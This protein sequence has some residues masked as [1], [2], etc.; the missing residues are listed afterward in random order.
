MNPKV[1]FVLHAHL[2][3]VRHIEYPKFLEENWLFESINETYIPLL[4]T[5]QNL[6]EVDFKISICFSPTLCAMLTD[7]M[8]Q[9]RFINY[10]EERITLGIK[11]VLRCKNEKLESLDM[12][13]KYLNSNRENLSYYKKCKRDLLYGFRQLQDLGKV[14]LLATAA[15]NIYFPVYKEYESVISAEIKIGIDEHI[16]YFGNKPDGFLLP[17]NGYYPGIEDFFEEFSIKWISLASSA[18][19]LAKNK[20]ESAGLCPVAI[21]ESSVLGF[22]R[23]WAITN[24]IWSDKTG[25]PCD[26]DY[27]DFYSDIG[28][29]L[30]LDYI[31]PFIHEPNVRVFTSYK[32][33]TIGIDGNKNIYN[34][35]KAMAKVRLNAANF[36]YNIKKFNKGNNRED[37]IINLFF[38]AELFGHRW[39]EGIEFLNQFLQTAKAS[40]IDLL[41]GADYIKEFKNKEY[42]RAYLNES[43][44]GY[45]GFSDTWV[46][47][48]NDWIYR[49]TFKAIERLEFIANRQSHEQGLKKRYYN[50]VAR[51]LLL[52]LA[53]DWPCILHNQTSINYAHDRIVHHLAAVDLVYNTAC[54]NDLDMQWLAYSEKKYNIFPNMDYNIFY[55]KDRTTAN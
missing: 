10:M 17:E 49:H 9:D 23:N 47:N 2:P 29:D 39:Y 33:N 30:P 51:E 19:T 20:I 8:L 5:L 36:I 53:S 40:G 46:D 18:V 3:F 15:T 54:K 6:N 44:S 27:R 43:S 48:S 41:S 22:S 13:I 37:S 50:Q 25:Y 21:G 1:N 32:Y 14:C 11:E 55:N 28:Y 35:D 4:K 38:D 42:E 24:K 16:R 26:K 45:G 52:S 34:Y 12:A 31:R 7:E